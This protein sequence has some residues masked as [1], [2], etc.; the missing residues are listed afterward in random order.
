M[1]PSLEAET[2][3]RT[4]ELLTDDGTFVRANDDLKSRDPLDWPGYR[5]ALEAAAQRT[6]GDESIVT[7]RAQISG[8]D[9]EIAIFDFAFIAGSM[10]EVAG[11][12]LARALERAADRR[13]PF[14]LITSTGGARMQEGMVSLVQMPKVVVA[15]MALAAAGRPLIAVLEHPTTGGVLAT[16]AALADMTAAVDGATV[17]FAGPR[18]VSRFTGS[19]PP[20]SSH[21]AQSA[22][23]NGLVDA[24]ISRNDRKAWL[25]RAVSVFETTSATSPSPHRGAPSVG[26]VNPAGPSRRFRAPELIDACASETVELR[27][28]RAGGDDPAIIGVLARVD[29]RAITMIAFDRR[30]DPG[31]RAFRKATRAL[32]VAARLDL[33]VVTLID[34]RGADPSPRA[35]S[36]G[37]AWAIGETIE[38][39]LTVPVPVIAIVT[40]D[41]GSGGA[42]ALAAGDVL[43]A[44]E[45]SIFSVIEPKAAAEI[46]W[47]DPTRAAEATDLLKLRAA[48]LVDF[49]IADGIVPDPPGPE[50]LLPVLA[51]HLDILTRDGR[52]GEQRALDR[53]RRWRGPIGS[54]P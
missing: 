32:A 2:A 26:A 43:L 19:P 13:V 33:P 38:A 37:I 28:D 52:S 51:Y 23:E 8:N 34:T 39:L 6:F 14:V 5:Q 4:I 25:S 18:V 31:P 15:R 16:A 10:G 3:E 41:G 9:V 22:F 21:T 53:R 12:R 11:E 30:V 24:L 35:E 40:G 20:P 45:S 49:G 1:R 44:Y 48:D 47:R 50:T 42:L 17:G 54:Q 46:L 36:G 27:G 7:G 29:G